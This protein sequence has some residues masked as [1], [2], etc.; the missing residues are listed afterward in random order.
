MA[1]A[2]DELDALQYVRAALG[3][4]HDMVQVAVNPADN[5]LPSGPLLADF[6]GA[7]AETL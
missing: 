4:R 6:P 1:A 3:T 7:L 5:A 2:G